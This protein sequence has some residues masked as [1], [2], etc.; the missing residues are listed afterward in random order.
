ML[1]LRKI[2]FVL[3]TIFASC[4][5]LEATTIVLAN[6]NSEKSI[7]LAKDYCNL[8]S[9]PYENI[10]GVAV[11]ETANISRADYDLKIA[12]VLFKF[13]KERGLI[14]DILNSENPKFALV[15]KSDVNYIVVAKGVPYRILEEKTSKDAKLPPVANNS[16][17]VDSELALLLK[18]KYDLRA[19]QKN[20]LFGL[21]REK[22]DYKKEK[23]LAITRLDGINY[24]DALN[25]AH[26]AQLAESKGLRGRAYID[27]S[28]KYPAGDKWL[29]STKKIIDELGFDV[30]S[31]EKPTL[32]TYFNRFDAPLFYF[33]WYAD[34]CYYY[35]KSKEVR[36]TNGASALHIYSFSAQSL[37]HPRVWVPSFVARNTAVAF[38]YIDEPF[39]DF[40]H[41]TDIYM[42]YISRGFEAG[43]AA[44]YAMSAFSWKGIALADPLFTP[45]K[46]TLA[47]ELKDIELGKADELSQYSVIRKMNLL[48][49]ENPDA[50]QAIKF[51]ETFLPKLPKKFALNW[52]LSQLYNGID[53]KK[54]LNLALEAT[55]EAK[56]AFQNF[57]L[58]F[59]I[60]NFLKSKNQKEKSAQLCLEMI[61][62]AT[63]TDFI[64]VTIPTLLKT[65]KFEEKERQMLE[66][67]LVSL[68]KK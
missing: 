55:D 34:K 13:L 36:Y 40:T 65:E 20:P 22:G 5:N 11:K 4:I 42:H 46:K 37:L 68:A 41:R 23:F 16:A 45:L 9:I 26:S 2:L 61:N 18:G 38:G 3:F 1:F 6:K 51:G 56:V 14:K 47:E 12:T 15:T 66:E 31:D 28:K 62:S 59:E 44:F 60:A 58:I 49:R 57:G 64:K 67:K 7:R 43:E 39:L 27:M 33:G 35:Q 21:N 10:V 25:I 48:L 54:S 29:A 17:C 30:T 50:I 8:R 63:D 24:Q 52:K 53:D 32:L 19:M